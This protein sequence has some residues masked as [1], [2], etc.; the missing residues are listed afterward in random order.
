MKNNASL[1]SEGSLSLHSEKSI[2]FIYFLGL[3]EDCIH[4]DKTTFDLY[5][6]LTLLQTVFNY[7]IWTST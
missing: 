3:K 6:N 7:S 5:T 1:H 2:I 4:P